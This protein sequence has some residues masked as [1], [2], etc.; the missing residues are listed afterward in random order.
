MRRWLLCLIAGASLIAAAGCGQLHD[1][2]DI[3]RERGMSGEYLSALNR[4]SRS[5]IVYSQLETQAHIRATYRSPEFNRAYLAEYA[6]IYPASPGDREGKGEIP[7]A[8]AGFTE[9][10]CYAYI[11][12]KSSNDFDRRGSIWSIFL[13]DGGGE[14]IDPVEIKRIEPVTA[15]TTEFFPYINPYYGNS[16]RLRFPPRKGSGTADGPLRLVFASVIARVELEFEA[17]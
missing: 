7:A 1:Y 2:R 15:V 17:R 9:F 10:I 13:I 11:P 3:F 5:Q 16:Y 8:A 6:S 12:E 14:R 4:W